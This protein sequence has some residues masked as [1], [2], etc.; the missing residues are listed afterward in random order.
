MGAA[1]SSGYRPDIIKLQC[2]YYEGRLS[3][4]QRLILE[5]AGFNWDFE[6]YRGA[7]GGSTDASNALVQN[8]RSIPENTNRYII[9]L[10]LGAQKLN[11]GQL[12]ELLSPNDLEYSNKI[13]TINGNLEIC[14]LYEDILKDYKI[15]EIS[16]VDRQTGEEFTPYPFVTRDCND[17]YI[18]HIVWGN[19]YPKTN[20]NNQMG[21]IVLFL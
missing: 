2:D 16:R 17:Y 7:R 13:F 9:S 14:V 1:N 10:I 3:E 18:K 4:R 20:D 19:I 15:M 11:P 21:K 8:G 6:Y 12:L 5:Q